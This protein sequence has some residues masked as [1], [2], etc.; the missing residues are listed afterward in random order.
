MQDAPGIDAE[1]PDLAVLRAAPTTLELEARTLVLTAQLWRDFMPISPPDG[2][3][4]AGLVT[5]GAR[6]GQALPPDL[7]VERVWVLNAPEVWTSPVTARWDDGSDPSVAA[8]AVQDGPK[9]GP[10]IAVDV[11]VRL[12]DAA[13]R[14]Y[15]LQAPHVGIRRTD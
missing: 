15:L 14:P 13:G 3:P 6:V 12:R 11:V 7:N 2:R 4:L 10:G 1:M 8:W 9:W 5:L